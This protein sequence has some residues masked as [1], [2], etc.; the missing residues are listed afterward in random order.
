MVI[1]ALDLNLVIIPSVNTVVNGSNSLRY[2][3]SVIWNLI[4]AD[5]RDIDNLGSFKA[6]IKT[7]KPDKCP[8]RLCT[9]YINGVGFVNVQ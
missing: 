6:V 2:F 8:C 9:D 3:G 4:P 1:T 7:W 5:I